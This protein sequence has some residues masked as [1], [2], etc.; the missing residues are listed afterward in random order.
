MQAWTCVLLQD[1]G[2]GFVAQP[3]S[4]G[5]C[6]PTFYLQGHVTILC[7]ETQVSRHGG[8]YVL[9]GSFTESALLHMAISAGVDIIQLRAQYPLLQIN[10]RAEQR[11]S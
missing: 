10:Y 1:C 5:R 8:E 9:T 2:F 11:N 4:R 3:P 6:L 7:N